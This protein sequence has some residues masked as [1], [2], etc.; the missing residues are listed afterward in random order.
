MQKPIMTIAPKKRKPD[1]W[2]AEPSCPSHDEPYLV[3][4]IMAAVY[5]RELIKILRGPHPL[6]QIGTGC[7]LIVHPYPFDEQ[8]LPTSDCRCFLIAAVQNAVK[9]M[10]LRMCLV[11]S[12]S[13]CAFVEL[14]G[15]VRDSSEPPSGGFPV[16]FKIAFDKRVPLDPDRGEV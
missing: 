15:L 7:C 10:G 11:W 9:A 2:S 1:D 14:D 4:R 12:A 3:V 13:S 5:Q 16:P 6:A 8:G